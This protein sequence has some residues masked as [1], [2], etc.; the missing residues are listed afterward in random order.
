MEREEDQAEFERRRSPIP[1]VLTRRLDRAGTTGG[2]LEVGMVDEEDAG[3]AIGLL[4]AGEGPR[5]I[6]FHKIYW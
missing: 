6:L 4:K 5:D 2:R 3:Y 1:S